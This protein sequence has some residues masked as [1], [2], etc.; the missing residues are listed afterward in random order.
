[1][2]AILLV[3]RTGSANASMAS[4]TEFTAITAAVLGGVAIQGGEGKLWSV[5]VG[6]F[7]LGILANGMQII[8]L[9]VY[10]QYIAKGTILIAAMSF[11]MYQKS[12]AARSVLAA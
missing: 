7:I 10:A 8:G 1:M 4:G 3:S 5:V 11:D 12:K 6:T 9:G 2:G